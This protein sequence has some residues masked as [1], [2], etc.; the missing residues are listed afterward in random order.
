LADSV[1]MG[2]APA[3]AAAAKSLKSRR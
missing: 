2:T 1:E 3:G